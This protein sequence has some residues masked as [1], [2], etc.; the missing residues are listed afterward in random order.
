MRTGTHYF[1]RSAGSVI[2]EKNRKKFGLNKIDEVNYYETSYTGHRRSEST[3]VNG[4]KS[5]GRE[6]DLM[7]GTGNKNDD[8]PNWFNIHPGISP[9]VQRRF[10]MLNCKGIECKY[11][12]Q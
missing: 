7:N 10:S 12:I 8:V 11:H 1:P 2:V 3:V 4:S 9:D 5:L 6:F